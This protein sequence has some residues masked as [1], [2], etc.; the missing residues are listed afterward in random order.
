MLSFQLF[1]FHGK[2]TLFN[3]EIFPRAEGFRLRSFF[4]VRGG[5]GGGCDCSIIKVSFN[6]VILL[7]LADLKLISDQLSR[8]D[9]IPARYLQ[10]SIW[11]L[12]TMKQTCTDACKESGCSGLA[13]K[14]RPEVFRT[15]LASSRSALD[16]L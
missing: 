11:L 10:T 14:D 7:T 8:I 15:V 4:F 13:Y 12:E 16:L 2:Y 5:G 3:F 1:C 9:Q 6:N